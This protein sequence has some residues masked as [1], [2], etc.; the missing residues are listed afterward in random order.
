MNFQN[1]NKSNTFKELKTNCNL[2]KN[3]YNRISDI[4]FLE[5]YQVSKI[6]LDTV[7]KFSHNGLYY[8]NSLIY[9][10]KNM[11]TNL[12]RLLLENGSAARGYEKY[13]G[14]PMLSI[15]ETMILNLDNLELLTIMEILINYGARFDDY[16][17]MIFWQKFH[18]LINSVNIQSKNVI[19]KLYMTSPFCYQKY[20]LYLDIYCEGF[21]ESYRKKLLIQYLEKYPVKRKKTIFFLNFFS[22]K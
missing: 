14:L 19:E 17:V 2:K 13:P 6:N 18:K 21:I 5:Y 7:T 9:A 10:I 20:K 3:F 1:S 15:I 8:E 12:I 11:K 4:E 16:V 22:F